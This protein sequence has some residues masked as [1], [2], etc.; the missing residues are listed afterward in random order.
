M[1][2][3]LM[4]TMPATVDDIQLHFLQK[5]WNNFITILFSLTEYAAL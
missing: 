4:H 2:E 5:Y 1:S 3:T